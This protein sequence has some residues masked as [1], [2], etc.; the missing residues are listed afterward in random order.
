[1]H[2]RIMRKWASLFF[3]SSRFGITD[4]VNKTKILTNLIKIFNFEIFIICSPLKV[5]N[6]IWQYHL[7]KYIYKSS[8]KK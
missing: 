3:S 8:K 5:L 2:I 7:N 6:N 1:M 4:L